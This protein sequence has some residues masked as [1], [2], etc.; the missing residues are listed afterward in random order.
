MLQLKVLTLPDARSE[1]EDTLD[2]ELTAM[3]TKIILEEMRA[4]R[5][6][7]GEGLKGVQKELSEVQKEVSQIR[8]QFGVHAQ[9]DLSAFEA[10]D[11]KF[12]DHED[13][14][15]KLRVKVGRLESERIKQKIEKAK[16]EGAEEV[17]LRWRQRAWGVV[18]GLPGFVK[19]LGVF[20]GVGALWEAGRRLLQTLGVLSLLVVLSGCVSGLFRIGVAGAVADARSYCDL[21]CGG[22]I[23]C[24]VF[25][26]EDVC[27]LVQ[28]MRANADE[29][30]PELDATRVTTGFTF[31]LVLSETSPTDVDDE[32]R[33]IGRSFTNSFGQRNHEEA[34]SGLWVKSAYWPGDTDPYAVELDH[35]LVHHILWAAVKD[36]DH[37]HRMK[38]LWR[39]LER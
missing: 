20:A 19:A 1:D 32:G 29:V 2:E 15:E 38:D 10:T 21:P 4:G 17:K 25:D 30:F 18:T 9:A 34:L 7:L 6:E 37:A 31:Q 26:D 13:K 16:L 28:K 24:G 36:Y 5:R 22:R 8:E 14:L 12:E 27:A 3:S 35:G 11:R 33:L 39:R 23:T